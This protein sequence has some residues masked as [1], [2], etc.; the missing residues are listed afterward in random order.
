MLLL[1]D[2]SCSLRIRN[3]SFHAN[4]L[5]CVILSTLATPCLLVFYLNFVFL[6]FCFLVLSVIY[7]IYVI[8]LSCLFYANESV[9]KCLILLSHF[10]ILNLVGNRNLPEIVSVACLFCLT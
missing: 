5:Y 10:A 2:A 8:F 6:F 7:F 3:F 1:S 9:I 4:L